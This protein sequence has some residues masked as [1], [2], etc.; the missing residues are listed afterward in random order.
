METPFT[1]CK[2]CCR[3]AGMQLSKTPKNWSFLTGWNHCNP[4]PW[5]YPLVSSAGYARA[6]LDLKATQDPWERLHCS[7]CPMLPSSA[8]TKAQAAACQ[9][10]RRL[11]Q[12]KIIKKKS[13]NASAAIKACKEKA[14]P[15]AALLRA[16]HGFCFCSSLWS[17]FG[18]GP[19][20]CPQILQA[21]RAADMSGDARACRRHEM[22]A[23][24]E[25]ASCFCAC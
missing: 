11:L 2:H 23:R 4:A 16:E 15:R 9:R 19:T 20:G 7:R 22:E 1:W 10:R 21:P 24:E 14:A 25:C 3:A 6:Q 18:L 17:E 8:E 5:A 12:K 13:I